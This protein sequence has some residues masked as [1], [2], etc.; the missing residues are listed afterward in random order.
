[1]DIHTVD[2]EW[3]KWVKDKTHIRAKLSPTKQSKSDHFVTTHAAS[4]AALR[5]LLFVGMRRKLVTYD[6]ANHWINNHNIIFPLKG[7]DG[8]NFIGYYDALFPKRWDDLLQA[9]AGLSDLWSLWNGFAKTI[10]SH[11]AHAIR[12]YDDEW[13][14][15]ALAIDRLFMM[16]LNK[17]IDPRI[18]GSP[19]KH[20]KHL[21]P[22]L[23]RGDSTIDVESL[24]KIKKKAKPRPTISLTDAKSRLANL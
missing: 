23:P 19:F 14:D 21:S 24:L 8:K 10:R 15:V 1:M 13:F 9:E 7:G 16:R 22:R 17:A 12:R 20:L 6:N 4:E 2:R 5:R 3:K 18:G 11:R